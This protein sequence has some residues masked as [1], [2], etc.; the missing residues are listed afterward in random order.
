[1]NSKPGLAPGFLLVRRH[2]RA[3]Q[4]AIANGPRECTPDDEHCVFR[5]GNIAG[6]ARL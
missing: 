4:G 3:P 5:H 2:D 6:K 1:M